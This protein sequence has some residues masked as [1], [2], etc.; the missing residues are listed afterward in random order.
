MQNKT[1]KIAQLA[2]EA[3]IKLAVLSVNVKNK[4]LI[5][6]AKSIKNNSKSIIA[7]NKKDL[8]E[9]KKS[10]LSQILIKRLEIDKDKINEM[11]TG[12]NTVVKLEDP[13]G[14]LI[15][16]VEMDDDLMLYQ[17]TCPIG[18]I[19]AIFESRP[20][21]IPQISSLCIK[22]GNAVILKGGS[23]AKN[24]NKFLFNLISETSKENKIPDGTV[25]LLE[26]R[27]DVAQM[28]KLNDWVNLIIPRGSNKF[29]GY[30]QTHTKIPVLGHSEGICH[31]FVDK[32]ADIKK[33]IDI[34]FD[35]KCQYPAACNAMETMLVHKDI[36]KKFLPLIVKKFKEAKVE[37]RGEDKTMQ[38]IKG[39]NKASEKDWSTEY[40]ELILSVKVVDN[41][42]DA[43]NHINKYSSKHT[44]SIITENKNSAT[45]FMRLV[46]SSSVMWNA[47]TRFADGFRYGKGA[48]IGISTAKIHSRGP[49]GL[50]GLVIYKYKLVGTGQVVKDYIGKS[51]KKFTHHHKV[52]RS[53]FNRDEFISK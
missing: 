23:E 14:K 22:S 46:D 20:D 47:S 18:V 26:T 4:A 42:N 37:I 25:Q 30:V 28:L 1:L 29:V 41:L 27:E 50:E 45:T 11:V 8:E 32:S 3:S 49:V 35:A 36:A 19:G 48:E 9:A 15:S 5:E 34:C 53:K 51:A 43:I 16:Q 44:D 33:A 13:V 52:K 6:I 40:N 12:I 38:I 31:V 10:K 24:T 21:A 2:K 17:V 39:I 7:A